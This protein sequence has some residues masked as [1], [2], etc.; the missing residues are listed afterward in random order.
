MR[1]LVSLQFLLAIFLLG[2]PSRALPQSTASILAEVPKQDLAQ[3][4]GTYHYREGLTLF[5]VS[6]GSQ[7]FALIE[8]S[9]YTLR[10]SRNDVF[11]NPVGDAVP[12]VRD[13]QGH[14]VAFKEQ[15]ETFT[16]RSTTVPVSARLRLQPR[17]ATSDGKIPSYRYKAPIQLADGIH[18]GRAGTATLSP[19]I[20]EQ[21]VNGVITGKYSDVDSL[22][23]YHKGSLVLEEYFYGFSRQQPHGMFHSPKVSSRSL[24]VRRLTESCFKQTNLCWTVS[25]IR[26]SRILIRERQRSPYLI[27]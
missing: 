25:G 15:G 6:N 5:M 19:E 12:F 26:S 10:R 20:A 18:V 4:E 27:C 2:Y 14:I 16:R 24:R 13:S 21:L 1:F 9:K 11:L 23:I 22:L 7:L 17:P 3:F 8:D